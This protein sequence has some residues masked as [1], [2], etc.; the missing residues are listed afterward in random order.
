MDKKELRQA[1]RDLP[2]MNPPGDYPRFTWIRRQAEI[3][4]KILNDDPSLFLTWPIVHE[5]LF[6]GDSPQANMELDELKKDGWWRWQ[7]G[8]RETTFGAP[9]RMKAWEDASGQMVHQ[10]Y[11]LKQWEDKAGK[12]VEDDAR[13]ILEF[14]GGYGSMARLC[15]QLGF[16]GVHVIYDLPELSW[17]QHYYCSQTGVPRV[18]IYWK[19]EWFEQ[20][21]CSITYDLFIAACSLSEVPFELRDF[22]LGNVR[23]RGYVILY[24]TH[25][26]GLENRSYFEQFAESKPGYEWFDY[27]VPGHRLGHR[28]LVGVER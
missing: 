20:V 10:A 27:E 16:E 25:F 18:F 3:R 21:V 23:T 26:Q 1:I 7:R 22:V 15:Y 14:G 4:E 8:I 12:R 2:P 19:P 13:A 17:L 5:A 28:Y 9:T 11:I 24:Q 6:V